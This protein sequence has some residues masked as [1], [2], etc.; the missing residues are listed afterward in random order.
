[1]CI[2]HVAVDET[3]RIGGI[4]EPSVAEALVALNSGAILREVV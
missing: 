1:M 2:F 4:N 3:D